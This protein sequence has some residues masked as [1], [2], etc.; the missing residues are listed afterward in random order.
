V[1]TTATGSTRFYSLSTLLLLLVVSLLHPT[2]AVYVDYD[3]VPEYA[4]ED[5]IPLVYNK[6]TSPRTMSSMDLALLETCGS[7]LAE[8]QSVYRNDRRWPQAVQAW[9]GDVYR[10]GPLYDIRMLE[11]TYCQQLCVLDMTGPVQ[12]VWADAVRDDYRYNMEVDGLPVAYREEDDFSVTNR[13][14]GGSPLGRMGGSTN[15]DGGSTMQ[16]DGTDEED[17]VFVNNHWN[18]EIVYEQSSSDPER[19]QIIRTTLQPYSVRHQFL[20]AAAGVDIFNPIASCV[21][22]ADDPSHTDYTMVADRLPQKASGKVLFTYDVIWRQYSGESEGA[23]RKRWNVFLTL[24]DAIPLSYQMASLIFAALINMAV[25]GVLVAWVLRDL[26]YRPVFEAQ[27][28]EGGLTEQEAAEVALWPLS[29]RVFRPPRNHPYLLAVL[30]GVGMHL[31]VA[32]LL[33]LVLYRLGI[34]NQSLGANLITPVVIL[35]AATT[36]VGGYVTGRLSHMF[37]ATIWLSM[38]TSFATAVGYP[39]IGIITV[40][41]CYDVFPGHQAPKYHVL[42]TGMPI[43]LVWFWIMIPLTMV[44][45]YF[46]HKRGSLAAFPMQEGSKSGPDLEITVEDDEPSDSWLGYGYRCWKVCRTPLLFVLGGVLPV[47]CCFAAFSYG[48]AGPIYLGYYSSTKLATLAPFLLFLSCSAGVALL[49][50]YRQLRI[51]QHSWWW[52]AFVTGSSSGL[53]IWLLA[54]TWLFFNVSAGDVSAGTFAIHLFWF[55]YIG[56]G[57]ACL[58]GSVAVAAC[59]TFHIF[60][61]GLVSTKSER[62]PILREDDSLGDGGYGSDDEDNLA[63]TPMDDDDLND[64]D[65]D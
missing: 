40:A 20:D 45:G 23:A 16:F 19:F 10:A 48:V 57:V 55:G 53:H 33:F 52:P 56:T 11:D 65:M 14:W 24:D 64:L 50:Q 31:L 62:E 32:A 18:I 28:E 38:A 9:H 6:L 26:S 61:R 13:F 59:L 46:G 3:S 42:S 22:N 39:L 47:L 35:V 63:L 8:G 58:C 27:G 21:E 7:V 54:L 25:F 1:T 49:L 36:P 2:R 37:G 44:G 17:D 51:Q 41:F 29:E 5:T 43:L 60:L 15:A 34:C 30:C 12:Y 4:E